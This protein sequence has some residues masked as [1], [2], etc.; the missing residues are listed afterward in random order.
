MVVITVMNS[1]SVTN[2]EIEALSDPTQG[3]RRGRDWKPG[4]ESP[5]CA[6]RIL[7]TLRYTYE[8]DLD[9]NPSTTLNRLITCMYVCV[10]ARTLRIKCRIW[11]VLGKCSTTEKILS[12]PWLC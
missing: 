10:C 7:C 5:V 8:S 6:L 2:E 9:S 11:L 4:A 3:Q 12:Q 1:S